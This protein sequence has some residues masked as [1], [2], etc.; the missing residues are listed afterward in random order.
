M[1]VEQKVSANTPGSR[2]QLVGSR[3]NSTGISKP[4][5]K[6]WR[7]RRLSDNRRT[8]GELLLF[9]MFFLDCSKRSLVS[10]AQTNLRGKTV[11]DWH[12]TRKQWRNRCCGLA[13]TQISSE[14]SLVDVGGGHLAVAEAAQ[15]SV[16]T[17]AV[18]TC[19]A[20]FL[21]RMKLA[22]HWICGGLNK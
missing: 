13:T 19:L 8:W 18:K 5:N 11:Y 17:S 10:R 7:D 15:Q 4:I 2:Q 20:Q 12:M 16:D 9:I 14:R 1:G 22:V 6:T 21:H 3:S